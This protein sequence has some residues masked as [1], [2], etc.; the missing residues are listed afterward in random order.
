MRC[1]VILDVRVSSTQYA[2]FA[3]LTRI[4]PLSASLAFDRG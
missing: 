2:Q 1:Y 4:A 3:V